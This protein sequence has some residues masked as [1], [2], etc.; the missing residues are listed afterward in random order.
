MKQLA[1]ASQCFGN[2]LHFGH[3]WPPAVFCHFTSNYLVITVL[4]VNSPKTSLVRNLIQ[5]A[6][7]IALYTLA[8]WQYSCNL[9]FLFIHRY[10]EHLLMLPCLKVNSSSPFFSWFLKQFLKF[11]TF[12]T[13]ELLLKITFYLP[14]SHWKG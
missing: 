1:N 5:C 11:P 4:I 12:Q 2:M 7:H 10:S 9:G 8:E 13:K 3:F 14:L 6:Y